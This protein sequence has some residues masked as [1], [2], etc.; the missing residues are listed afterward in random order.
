MDDD[1]GANLKRVKSDIELLLKKVLT[2]YEYQLVSMKFGLNG[3]NGGKPLSYKN[4]GAEYG[5]SRNTATND[6]EKILDKIKQYLDQKN[7]NQI[8]EIYDLGT[9]GRIYLN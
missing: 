9:E 1:T 5:R 8:N 7:I 3:H 4:L 6:I 2:P